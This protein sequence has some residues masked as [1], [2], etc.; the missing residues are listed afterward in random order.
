VLYQ[1][2]YTHHDT[3][4]VAGN[5]AFARSATPIVPAPEECS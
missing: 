2:S 1:L 5:R 3:A 4:R